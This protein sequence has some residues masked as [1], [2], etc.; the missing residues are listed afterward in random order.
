MKDKEKVWTVFGNINFFLK[1]PEKQ[2]NTRILSHLLSKSA[3]WDRTYDFSNF[4]LKISMLFH[5]LF[6][7]NADLRMTYP[8]DIISSVI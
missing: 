6:T 5:S 7:Y 1:N 3:D 2:T 4:S 8:P